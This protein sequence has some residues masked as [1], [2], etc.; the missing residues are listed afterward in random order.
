MF[1]IALYYI[2]LYSTVSYCVVLYCAVLYWMILWCCVV[3]I[4]SDSFENQNQYVRSYNIN[5]AHFWVLYSVFR[6]YILF[7]FSLIFCSFLS[8]Y[9]MVCI[10]ITFPFCCDIILSFFQFWL[11]LLYFVFYLYFI[12]SSNIWMYFALKICIWI[13]MVHWFRRI[14]LDISI[15]WSSQNKSNMAISIWILHGWPEILNNILLECCHTN[16]I[17][18]CFAQNPF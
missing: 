8:L 1:H 9:P 11:M 2:V 15:F 3:F 17:N 10:Y 5:L 7:A 14:F 6:C 16:F 12:K 13:I 4:L 18:A